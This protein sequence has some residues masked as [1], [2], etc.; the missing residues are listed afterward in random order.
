[1]QISKGKPVPFGATL[2]HEGINFSIV[3]VHASR[4]S[5]CL[6]SPSNRH[7]P[8]QEIPLDPII[9]K[10]GN[11]WHIFLSE[12]PKG[13]LYAYR[14]NEGKEFLLDPYALEVYTTNQWLANSNNYNPLGA[15]PDG[16]FD[17]GQDA[18]P[19]IPI[20]NLILYEMHVR[21]FTQHSSSGVS[22]P[23][24]YPG[25]IEKIPY[26]LDLGVNALELLP[27]HEFNEA[28]YNKVNPKTKKQL[29]NFWGYSTI[30]FFSPMQRYASRGEQG[31]A[32]FEFKSMVKE[33]HKNGI[34]VI[35]DVVYNHTGEGGDPGKTYSFKGLDKNLYYITDDK[36]HYLNFSGCGNTVSCNHPIMRELIIDS[37]RYWVSEMHVDGFRFDL[38]SILTRGTKGQPLIYSPLIERISNDPILSRVKLIA[39]PWD[40]GG[41]YQVGSFFLHGYGRWGEWNGRYR[42]VMRRFIKGTG[43]NSEFG[44]N[45]S[46]SQDFYHSQTPCT[47]VNFITAHDGFTL[48]D[49]VTYSRKHNYEN[50]ED[51]RDG[52]NH[53]NS[54]NYGIE[55]PTHN[56]V[57]STLRMRQMKNFHLA[58]MLSRGMPMLL[59]GD[60]YGHTKYGNNNTWCHDSE[61]NWFLWDKLKENQS[62]YRFYKSLIHFRKNN[63]LL[64]QNKFLTPEEVTWHGTKPLTPNWG[65]D[66]HIIAFTLNDL[67]H[68]NDLYAAFNTCG[69]PIEIEIPAP[70]SHHQWHAIV[71]T[72]NPS[73]EDF[74][75][76]KESSVLDKLHHQLAPY[77]SLLLKSLNQETM[78]HKSI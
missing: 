57:I 65:A 54:W 42:D 15:L 35:L 33:L 41:L 7:L 45:F 27:V 5:L 37:L 49:L 13:Y 59:M 18:P 68:G 77:S 3:S 48:A 76:E 44:T 21:G 12:V 29:C 14:V 11:V 61:L 8:E 56:I 53:N 40:A 30:N 51:N 17:W 64:C 20:Q 74:R 28:E 9:N 66:N 43:S 47:S 19:L 1:M 16:H 50:G 72:A 34:E 69:N 52:E 22:R 75:G 71:N 25:V 78:L 4:L 67:I 10:T 58:L 38:A 60:E 73:P 31:A 23:G 70:K 39:E 62:F 32:I 24:S 6:F 63:P 26:L 36:G 2:F 46:G 55:G